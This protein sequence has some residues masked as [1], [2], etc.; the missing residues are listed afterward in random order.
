M[1]KYK[2]LNA[3]N[4]HNKAEALVALALKIDFGKVRLWPASL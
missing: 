2:Y 1:F 3:I 4:V